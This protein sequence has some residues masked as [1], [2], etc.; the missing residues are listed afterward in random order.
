MS[1]AVKEKL[2]PECNGPM[3][4]RRG[5]FGHF[6]GCRRFPDCRGTRTLD[7]PLQEAEELDCAQN[8]ATA[9]DYIRKIGGP[10]KASR[11]LKIAIEAVGISRNKESETIPTPVRPTSERPRENPF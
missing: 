10:Q 4:I 2:C 7:E 3:S 8:L 1:E 11:W 6:Y 5:P 9:W